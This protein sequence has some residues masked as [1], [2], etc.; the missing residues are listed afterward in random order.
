MRQG[1]SVQENIDLQKPFT[2]YEDSHLPGFPPVE[3]SK[4]VLSYFGQEASFRGDIA[5]SVY[6]RFLDID[7]VRFGQVNPKEGTQVRID[8]LGKGQDP[9]LTVYAVFQD[10]K[11]WVGRRRFV[12][13]VSSSAVAE[14]SPQ[15]E[16]S[17]LID[18]ARAGQE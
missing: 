11:L 2:R 1:R 15:F 7:Y 13:D 18:P 17:E 9:P 4:S 16:D 12:T 8:D 3:I 5:T 10:G 6:D 14:P